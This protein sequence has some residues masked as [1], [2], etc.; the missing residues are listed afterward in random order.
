MLK[1]IEYPYFEGVG[2]AVIYEQID[3]HEPG[4][5]VYV[6]NLNNDD[7]YGVLVSSTGYG[8]ID[9]EERK[10]STLRHFLDEMGPLSFKRVEPLPDD[11][12]QLNNEYWLSFYHD[13][14]LYDRKFVFK[15]H[16]IS[17]EQAQPVQLIGKKGFIIL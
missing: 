10:T 9:N 2:L 8:L 7:L 15:A 13:K 5:Y 1:D 3:E 11:L 16:S 6:V 17:L 14:K 4:W 12:L